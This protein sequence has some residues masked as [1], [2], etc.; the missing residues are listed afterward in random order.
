MIKADFHRGRVVPSGAYGAGVGADH[1]D[2]WAGGE[3]YWRGWRSAAN[4]THTRCIR[5]P[6]HASAGVGRSSIRGGG[7]RSPP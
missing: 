3:W 7:Q 4:R 5:T 2:G 1:G 6:R